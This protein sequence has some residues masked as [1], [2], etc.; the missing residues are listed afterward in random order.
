[1]AV[2]LLVSVAFY[3]YAGL[4]L[5]AREISG[6]H[7]KYLHHIPWNSTEIHGLPFHSMEFHAVPWSIDEVP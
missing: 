1:M 7:V 6:S 3:A 2:S 5:R 4:S